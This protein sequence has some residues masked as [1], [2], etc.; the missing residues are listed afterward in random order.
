MI[1]HSYNYLL[2]PRKRRTT[3]TTPGLSILVLLLM[4]AG[5][6][7]EVSD[8]TEEATE[9]LRVSRQAAEYE[10]QQAL[11]LLWPPADHTK[12][13]SNASVTLELVRALAPHQKVIITAATDSVYTSAFSTLGDSLINH[14]NIE[15]LQ[16]P[17]E[18]IWVRDM[19]PTF[20]EMSDGSTAVVNFRFNAWGYSNEEDPYTQRMEAYDRLAANKLD[21]PIVNSNIISEGGNREMNSQGILMLTETVTTQRNPDLSKPELETEFKRVLGAKKIIWLK[22]GLLEDQHSFL[23]PLTT[24]DGE[25]VYTVVTTN[26]HIDEYARFVNDSTILLADVA[27]EELKDPIGKVNKERMERNLGLIQAA[28]DINNKPFNIERLPLP[29]P[30]IKTMYPGDPVYDYLAELDYLDQ[31]IFPEGDPVKV[32]AAASY[33][34][35]II[36]NELIIAQKYGSNDAEDPNNERDKIAKAILERLFPDK[37][38]IQIDALSVNLGGGGLHCISMQQPK[39]RTSK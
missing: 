11:W 4:L 10:P 29:K 7:T 13:L 16:L 24:A 3:F 9:P 5:C 15:L 26:G 35:F 22:E 28:G 20:V 1:K 17:S 23:G 14:P 18:E 33:L 6:K 31:S 12:A 32:I 39:S 37:L 2:L 38:V 25:K 34:N 30:V 8:R 19:G 36:T 27:P 21:L